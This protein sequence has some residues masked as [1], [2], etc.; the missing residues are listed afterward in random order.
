M[1]DNL[2]AA[3]VAFVQ[4]INTFDSQAFLRL[5]LIVERIVLHNKSAN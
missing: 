1:R 3:A 4:A 5:D 2:P